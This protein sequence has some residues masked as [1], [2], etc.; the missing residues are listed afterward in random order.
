M[1]FLLGW[2]GRECLL[3]VFV[4]TLDFQILFHLPNIVVILLLH[5][6]ERVG[7]LSAAF[8]DI[9]VNPDKSVAAV[10]LL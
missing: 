6:V 8:L 7:H 2:Q 10:G 4:H 1:T 9:Q 3:I 5:V